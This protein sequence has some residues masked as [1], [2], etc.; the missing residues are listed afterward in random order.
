MPRVRRATTAA[1]SDGAASGCVRWG[2]VMRVGAL[3]VRRCPRSA[4]FDCLLRT[5]PRADHSG[6]LRAPPAAVSARPTTTIGD[7]RERRERGH[8]PRGDRQPREQLA[9]RRRPRCRAPVRVAARPSEKATIRTRP[10]PIRCCATAPSSTTSADGH[11]I[12]PADAPSASRL[13]GVIR[14]RPWLRAVAWSWSCVV[15]V[16][17]CASWPRCAARPRS[18]A[19][20]TPT[21][22]RPD[23]S[24]EPRVEL[25]RQ[26]PGGER[27]AR[28]RRARTTPAVCVTV[29][30]APSA[31]ASRGSRACRRGRRR[32][33]PCRGPG[34][35]AC[36]A[37]QPNAASSSRTSTPSPAS[38]P[39]EA[40]ARAARRRAAP[41][42]AASRGVERARRRARPRSVAARYVGAGS[43]AG[44]RDSG[45]GR[46]SG[47][48]RARR[49]RTA[50]PSPG[51][52]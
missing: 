44:R 32:P 16:V 7:G 12:R 48:S 43:R 10:S 45:A 46:P 50:V 40:V 3:L 5:T 18:T 8:E 1:V 35:S 20:P 21:T 24:V 37:P 33:S 41:H 17:T 13:R 34:E 2:T 19:A 4:A 49:S 22:S 51:R 28:R 25:L 39:G 36:S 52:A 6:D 11:G 42:G 31:M 14:S 9:R 26:D 38:R 30:V 27:R 15:V 23:T 47:R 29:T